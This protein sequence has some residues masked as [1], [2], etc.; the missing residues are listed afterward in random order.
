VSANVGFEIR[1]R[2]S[3]GSNFWSVFYDLDTGDIESIKPGEYKAANAIVVSYSKI[4]DFLSGE[5]SQSEYKVRF[6]ETLGTLD[7]VDQTK[8]NEILNR[9]D[10][11]QWLNVAESG[12]NPISSIRVV[13]FGDSGIFRIEADRTWATRL[14]E[15]LEKDNA[16]EKIPMYIADASDPHLILG[17]QD[18]DLNDVIENGYW[19][20]RLWSFMNHATV[21]Q[22][23]YHGKR[24]QVSIPPIAESICFFRLGEYYPFTGVAEEQT[25]MSHLG[26]GKHISIFVNGVDVWAKSHYTKGS[27]LDQIVGD[28]RLAIVSKDDPEYFHDWTKL[29]A[30][31]LRQEHPFKILDN[32]QYQTLPHVL[33]KAN[34]LDIGVCFGNPNQ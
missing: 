16:T 22:V 29:P 19:E 26:Q 24:V 4:K 8:L 25:V 10:W 15:G 2:K 17:R 14:K 3:K 32:W 21:Q 30:L 11:I 13:L 23:L 34:N 33:Y 27:S 6:N 20:G 31:M 5:A 7:I 28:L 9:L 18:I 12:G 1:V